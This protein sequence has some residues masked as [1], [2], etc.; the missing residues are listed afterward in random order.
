MSDRGHVEESQLVV[1]LSVDFP[2]NAPA[3]PL[4]FTIAFRQVFIVVS[5]KPISADRGINGIV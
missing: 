1:S 4:S 2:A 3:L 5:G